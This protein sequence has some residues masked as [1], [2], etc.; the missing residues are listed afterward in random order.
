MGSGITVT[1]SEITDIMKVIKYL[2]NRGVLLKGTATEITIQE[3]GFL[4]F[5]RPLM[6]AGY[7]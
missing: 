2:E 1:N 7:H 3:G 4:N 6:A 5:V